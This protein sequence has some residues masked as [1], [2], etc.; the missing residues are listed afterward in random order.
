M[1]E[2][3]TRRLVENP[4][5]QGAIVL[6]KELEEAGL[7]QSAIMRKLKEDG[8]P[9]RGEG[10]WTSAMVRKLLD[11]DGLKGRWAERKAKLDEEYGTRVAAAEADAREI[12][13]GRT[14]ASPLD[15]CDPVAWGQKWLANRDGSA[16][17]YWRHQIEDLRAA[18]DNIV[19][20]DGR[21][22]GKTANLTTLALHYAM[23]TRK[24]S[25]L[26][27]AAL[28]GQLLAIWEEI[29]FQLE[30]NPRLEACI[31]RG[32]N[33]HRKMQRF[34]YPRLEFTNGSVLYFRPA[35]TYGEAFRS[36]HVDRVWVDEGAWLSEDAWRALRQCLKAGG[37]LRVYSTPNGMRNATYYRL[38]NSPRWRVFRWPSWL[39]PNWTPNHEADLLEFYGGRATAGWQHEV[40]GE[41]GAPS[42]GAFHPE[43]LALALQDVPEYRKIVITNAELEDCQSELETE[44]RFETLLNIWPDSAQYYL[45]ADLGY[46]NDPT[47]ILV[48]RQDTPKKSPDCSPPDSRLQTPD[49]SLR[50]VLRVHMEKVAYPHIA[51]CLA[52]IDSLLAPAAIGIDNGGNGLAVI[53]ELMSL[54]KYKPRAFDGRLFGFDFGGVTPFELPNGAQTKKRT[55]E[56]MTSLIN[57]ALQRREI[58]FPATD[59]EIPDQFL[60]Q[61]YS[62]NNGAVTYSKGNDHIID[63]TR[64]MVLAQEKTAPNAPYNDPDYTIRPPLP[65]MVEIFTLPSMK[66]FPW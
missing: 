43:H 28:A 23:T 35:G 5:E 57:K 60:T 8:V 47:E 54:D 7:S 22:V 61:T 15:K 56:L 2:K 39:N 16:R 32:R 53:Q 42:Y 14:P 31:A 52:V 37:K 30:N 3:A 9:N 19:H 13:E 64:C 34:P 24:G 27:A 12:A 4:V 40:A 25:G 49:C 17:A 46:T 41:H 50:L 59:P 11:Y 21:D 10:L 44:Q 36:L 1:F 51:Q 65:L 58:V 20:L 38:T 48:F 18:D 63:A 55:K 6:A 45:G 66:N 29:E 62:L 33:G 26:V